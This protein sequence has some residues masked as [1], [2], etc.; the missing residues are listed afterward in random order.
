MP[1]IN[2]S[3]FINAPV[4]RCFDLARSIDMHMLS[5]QTTKEKAIA[6]RT[7]GLIN[8]GETV[9]WEAVHFFIR[10]KLTVTIPVMDRPHFFSDM[11]LEGAFKKMYH[12][13][14]FSQEGQITLMKDHF[15]YEVPYGIAGKIFDVI[16]LKKY[17]TVFL[18]R[19]NQA[20]K[21]AAEG[22]GWKTILK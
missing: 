8:E 22:G 16:V 13:H 1:I 14:Y 6:G 12:E 21:Y 2:L 19:R 15:T 3:T 7:S 4:E 17:M 10:Q 18:T 5:V 11:M 9:T 20:I